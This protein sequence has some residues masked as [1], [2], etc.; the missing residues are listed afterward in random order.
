MKNSVFLKKTR[1]LATFLLLLLQG[2]SVTAPYY[3]NVSLN[4]Y[5]CSNW[6]YGFYPDV[7][8]LLGC[9]S[10]EDKERMEYEKARIPVVG[11]PDSDLFFN[12]Y[13]AA[14]ID[15][16][17]FFVVMQQRILRNTIYLTKT[18]LD[19]SGNETDYSVAIHSFGI[20]EMSPLR[21]AYVKGWDDGQNAA[22]ERAKLKTK[23]GGTSIP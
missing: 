8:D 1:V 5:D 19:T 13:Q 11:V 15:G 2:C 21:E 22:F 23:N 12:V 18:I 20:K 9:L 16:Y 10:D 3:Y 17:S 14:Y 6:E 4:K 7:Q